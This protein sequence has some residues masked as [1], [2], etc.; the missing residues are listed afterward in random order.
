MR[1]HR[2][3]VLPLAILAVVAAG[4]TAGNYELFQLTR[5]AAIAIAVIGLDLL[6]G[7]TGQISAGHSA[8]MGVG[9][10]VTAIAVTT[11]SVHTIPA[12]AIALVACALVGLCLGLPAIRIAGFA[13][14]LTTVGVAVVFEPLM[15][16]WKSFTRGD[17][18]I[19]TPQVVPPAVFDF[20]SPAQWLFFVTCALLGVVWGAVRYFTSTPTGRSLDAVRADTSMAASCGIDVTRLKLGIF[21]LS[22]V[23][24]GLGGVMQQLALGYATPAAYNFHLS[25]TLIVAVVIG[26]LRSRVGNVIGAAVIVLVPEYA[27]TTAPGLV[28]ALVL[29]AVLYTMPD[30]IAGLPAQ[31]RDVATR[32]QRRLK[33]TSERVIQNVETERAVDETV[34]R[35]FVQ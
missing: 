9:A 13:L 19:T 6:L 33:P 32:I 16:Y 21:V 20:L 5:I 10:Y 17:I 25:L 4:G 1:R 29:L 14:A 12:A 22:A 28:Y 11:H 27:G 35:E 30:G 23:I 3:I 18:G 15:K 24:A 26:G 34:E 2:T 7:H 31:L 8:L